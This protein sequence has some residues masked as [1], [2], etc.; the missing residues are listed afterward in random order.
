MLDEPAELRRADGESVF[1]DTP[2]PDTRAKPCLMPSSD[3]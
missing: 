3:C 1:T 2:R